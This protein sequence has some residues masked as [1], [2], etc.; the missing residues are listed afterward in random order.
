[1][2]DELYAILR[3]AIMFIQTNQLVESIEKYT[4]VVGIGIIG[5]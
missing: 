1:M 2:T 5:A 3:Y 4:D